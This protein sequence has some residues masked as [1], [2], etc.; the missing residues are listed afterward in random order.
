MVYEVEYNGETKRIAVTVGSNGFI[1]GANPVGNKKA[2]TV[3]EDDPVIT[4][5]LM[6]EWRDWPLRV[7][8]DAGLPDSYAI[9][10]IGEVVV[11]SSDLLGAI[12]TWD[13]A[14]QS[15]WY[16]GDGSLSPETIS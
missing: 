12:E 8:E 3:E 5:T 2:R 9:D 16:A 13:D 1:V 15:T 7:A 11:L 10:E 14:F 6:A 4:L